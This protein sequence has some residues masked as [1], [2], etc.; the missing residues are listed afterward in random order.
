VFSGESLFDYFVI[1]IDKGQRPDKSDKA[2]DKSDKATAG[3]L[4]FSDISEILF[5]FQT[6]S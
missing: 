4:I 1:Y 2:T 6:G 5:S 3:K